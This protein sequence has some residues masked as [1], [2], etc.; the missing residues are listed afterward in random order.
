[1]TETS[2]ATNTARRRSLLTL[3]RP[4]KRNALS[5]G[6]IAALT[7]R[8]E[9]ARDDPAAR[10]VILTGA[11]PAF[12]AGMDLTE[13]Q[14]VRSSA[15]RDAVWDDALKLARLLR[16]HL[17]AAQA[18]D[19]RGQRPGG[20]RRGRAGDG[21]RPGRGRAGG[22][23]RLSRRCGAGLVAAMVMPHLL[24]HVGER[25]GPLAAA[26]RRTDRR[27]R[28]RSGSGWSTPSCRPTELLPTADAVGAVA[29]RGRAEGAGD[30]E[31][32]AAAVLAAGAVGRGGGPGAAPSRG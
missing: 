21:L 24:R 16:P 27:R 31:G 5:R 18:D 19:R 6:L 10:C 11:G 30:D 26:H 2:S 20:R 22:E 9:R 7:R 28:G 23:V 12:C 14:R 17:H 4:D 29:G 1:M 25:T 8:F 32:F 15:E 3:N 13:L